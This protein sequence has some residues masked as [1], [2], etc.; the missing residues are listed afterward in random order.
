[1]TIL[2]GTLLVSQD[3]LTT[4]H[5]RKMKVQITESYLHNS[6]GQEKSQSSAKKINHYK[7]YLLET[8]YSCFILYISSY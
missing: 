4:N 1:M 8:V 5:G 3:S 2:S 6:F 7:T